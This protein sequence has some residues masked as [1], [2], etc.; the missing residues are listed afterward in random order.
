MKNVKIFKKFLAII[1]CATMITNNTLP[2]L[3]DSIAPNNSVNN[4]EEYETTEELNSDDV[5]ET[6]SDDVEETTE[7]ESVVEAT[8]F[9]DDDAEEPETDPVEEPETDPV[10]EYET[11]NAGET[12][13]NGVEETSS[14]QEEEERQNDAST[15]EEETSTTES[16][17][18]AEENI[19]TQSEI[20]KVKEENDE[21]PIASLSEIEKI[22]EAPVASISEIEELVATSS[23]IITDI[24]NS[25]NEETPYYGYIAVDHEA[26][27][28]HVIDDGLFRASTLPSSYDSREKTNSS[29]GLSYIS[30]MRDQD[31]YGSCW[32]FSAIAMFESSLRVK[33]LVKNETE[34][35]LSEAAL[36][37]YTYGLEDVTNDTNYIDSP[38]LEGHDYSYVTSG[39]FADRGGNQYVALLAASSYQGVVTEDEESSYERLRSYK[40]GSKPED[41]H[42]TDYR[43]DNNYAFKKNNFV[44]ENAY[45]INKENTDIIKQ[46]I[47]E[48]G[49]VGIS[50][51]AGQATPGQGGGDKKYAIVVDGEHYYFTNKPQTESNHAIAIVGWDDNVPK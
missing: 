35:N 32:A 30:P 33:G 10:D 14:L 18:I 4:N 45:F 29:T 2:I 7:G 34:S 8:S 47:M 44:L 50:Y 27:V 37:Y 46:K 28:V 25:D 38:G 24:T 12:S 49:A 39:R 36:L 6:T 20:E 40:T 42:Q 17:T 51:H 15:V 41:D 26:P 3:A 13:N 16:E 22:E 5:V 23:E 21:A 11:D 9:P 48:N 1:L 31:P 43:L 19:S